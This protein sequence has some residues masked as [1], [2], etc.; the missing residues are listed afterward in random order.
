MAVLPIREKT[1][2]ATA[3]LRAP[4]RIPTS[5]ARIGGR[6]APVPRGIN[7]AIEPFMPCG[8]TNTD[9]SCK[10]SASSEPNTDLSRK[11]THTYATELSGRCR[12][13]ALSARD[14]ALQNGTIPSQNLRRTVGR[15]DTDRS[16]NDYRLLT[17]EIPT[18]HATQYRS[19]A[20]VLP[21]FHARN[22]DHWS[23]NTDPARKEYRPLAQ[24]EKENILQMLGFRLGFSVSMYV[25]FLLNVVLLQTWEA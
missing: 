19:L 9:L 18:S 22:T 25:V 15:S 10:T 1:Q 8:V 4:H 24:A 7:R 16:G 14:K 3:C 5:H 23:K 2:G 11:A 6:A 12:H 13:R 17:Q 21:T 20:Q